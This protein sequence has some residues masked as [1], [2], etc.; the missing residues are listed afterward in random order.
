M[1]KVMDRS[2]NGICFNS[3]TTTLSEECKKR[4]RICYHSFVPCYEGSPHQ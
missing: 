3:V 1:L 4:Q 2:G